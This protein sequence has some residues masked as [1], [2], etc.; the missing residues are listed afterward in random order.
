MTTSPSG[1]T[2]CCPERTGCSMTSAPGGSAGGCSSASSGT[3]AAAESRPPMKPS[4]QSHSA[5]ALPDR[6]APSMPMTRTPLSC[7]AGRKDGNPGSSAGARLRSRMI[8]FPAKNPAERSICRS[9][10]ISQLSRG[11]SGV[12]TSARNERPPALIRRGAAVEAEEEDAASDDGEMD[13]EAVGAVTVWSSFRFN[14]RRAASRRVES[15]IAYSPKLPPPGNPCAC[16]SSRATRSERKTCQSQRQREAERR[17]ACDTSCVA[18]ACA[19]RT[20]YTLAQLS[21]MP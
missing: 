21:A 11:A 19:S 10:A 6:S 13:W 20:G 14:R 9:R 4:G 18:R 5:N 3:S 8:G 15:S 17:F 1:H 2:I 16:A 12:R 7:K